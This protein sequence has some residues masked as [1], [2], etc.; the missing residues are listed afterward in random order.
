MYKICA[1]KRDLDRIGSKLYQFIP[2]LWEVVTPIGTYQLK[3]EDTQYN[4]YQNG[5]KTSLFVTSI[6]LIR[7]CV[8]EGQQVTVNSEGDSIR[9]YIGTLK[10]AT[11]DG[12][13]AVS[14]SVVFSD[15]LCSLKSPS[16]EYVDNRLVREE[17]IIR[18][19]QVSVYFDPRYLSIEHVK[20]NGIEIL[21]MQFIPEYIERL[22]G[23]NMSSEVQ[24]TQACDSITCSKGDRVVVTKKEGVEY[25]IVITKVTDY[26]SLETVLL[27]NNDILE[28]DVNQTVFIEFQIPVNTYTLYT[29]C[30]E[31]HTG[32]AS[33]TVNAIIDGTTTMLLDS[34]CD[35]FGEYFVTSTSIQ[36]P[37][38]K[39]V[40]IKIEATC[41]EDLGSPAVYS[42]SIRNLTTYLELSKTDISSNSTS[43]TGSFIMPEADCLVSPKVK[44]IYNDG[45]QEDINPVFYLTVKSSDLASIVVNNTEYDLTNGP[46]TMLCDVADVNWDLLDGYISK[47][48]IYSTEH[49]S[50][51]FNS[52]V[53]FITHYDFA[54]N[55]NTTIEISLQQVDCKYKSFRG[56]ITSLD[57]GKK[58]NSSNS[59][60]DVSGNV[61]YKTYYVD[62]DVQIADSGEPNHFEGTEVEEVVFYNP[63]SSFY[64][65]PKAFKKCE[66]LKSIDLSKTS[67]IR[68]KEDAFWGSFSLS[69][70]KNTQAISELG[71]RSFTNTDLPSFIY[72]TNLLQIPNYAFMNCRD[73]A[74]VDY[75][76][77]SSLT[78]VG[79]LSFDN[80][81][82]L[83]HAVFPVSLSEIGDQCFGDNAFSAVHTVPAYCTGT[84]ADSE[85][86]VFKV[87]LEYNNHMTELPEYAFEF[88]K[89]IK[90]V[91]L[92]ASINLIKKRAFLDCDNIKHFASTGLEIVEEE[93]FGDTWIEG[94]E[95]DKLEDTASIV[96]SHSRV[97]GLYKVPLT[98]GIYFDKTG[99][100]LGGLTPNHSVCTYI[101]PKTDNS[102]LILYKCNEHQKGGIGD[103]RYMYSIHPNTI[104]ISPYAF[105]GNYDFGNIGYYAD[106][107]WAESDVPID[108]KLEY[109]GKAAFYDN[110]RLKAFRF[111]KKGTTSFLGAYAF[112]GC[113]RLS[114]VFNF[115]QQPITRIEDYTFYN[116]GDNKY[117]IGA[118]TDAGYCN[119]EFYIPD[120]TT[121]IG[122]YA[123]AKCPQ[124]MGIANLANCNIT[125]IGEG[126]FQGCF[127][128]TAWQSVEN[129]RIALL[130]AG[131]VMAAVGSIATF[132]TTALAIAGGTI[133]LLGV[134]WSASAA[135]FIGGAA[136]MSLGGLVIA[137]NVNPADSQ[138][139]ELWLP[140]VTNIGKAAFKDCSYLTAVI[141]S[142]RLTTIAADTFNSCKKFSTLQGIPP[143]YNFEDTEDVYTSLQVTHIGER[144]FKGC[145]SLS[146]YTMAHLLRIIEVIDD[147]AFFKA[148]LNNGMVNRQ[149]IIPN[150]I[151]KLGNRSLQLNNLYDNHTREWVFIHQNPTQI[152][153]GTDVFPNKYINI[154]IPAGSLNNYLQAFPNLTS[155]KFTEIDLNDQF[156][157]KLKEVGYSIPWLND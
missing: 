57:K 94:I 106:A 4:L 137:D 121:S 128:N 23:D 54:L 148:N 143:T 147:D 140:K 13:K 149:I 75:E 66:H 122:D 68:V 81:K 97:P 58:W 7:D 117:G 139:V 80:C 9:M 38:Q 91:Y 89:G 6:S 84:I 144:A 40:Q 41:A 132:G 103:G 95:S 98:T 56:R 65:H 110:S 125:S 112:Y 26:Y 64:I 130:V 16:Q 60:L 50:I 100:S 115:K 34:R 123:F 82:K 8:Y 25:D 5:E 131:I 10:R 141:V 22:P 49:P 88:C 48:D 69:D 93:A 42:P 27:N 135:G 47:V 53:E 20:T 17:D 108:G 145:E 72:G 11:Q 24:K 90:E 28:F 133:P 29:H 3:Y 157:Y 134:E 96:V 1:T 152:D 30:G 83:K 12:E 46:V 35:E 99:A 37:P 86:C 151:T 124:L 87:D 111:P 102:V 55:S 71:Q 70:F 36:V 74:D 120:T 67:D 101:S 114:E 127:K 129:K 79:R 85:S 18:P 118:S 113:T 126:A 19:E 45:G 73:L 15:S 76:S 138:G 107:Q 92:P 109:I 104:S 14:K 52:K 156:W 33:I 150:S 62:T 32:P 59:I 77:T 116:C 51:I 146:I 31:I 78:S 136:G 63:A 43:W 39:E 21:P 153:C 155:D 119:L 105:S 61:P 154:H 142:D 44:F 2:D